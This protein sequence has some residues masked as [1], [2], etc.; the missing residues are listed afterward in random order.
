MWLYL[1]QGQ[2]GLGLLQLSAHFRNLQRFILNGIQ[3]FS[4]HIFNGNCQTHQPYLEC[5]AVVKGEKPSKRHIP[6]KASG[7]DAK[8]SEVIR[9]KIRTWCMFILKDRFYHSH[10]KDGG[11]KDINQGPPPGNVEGQSNPYSD[12]IGSQNQ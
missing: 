9:E 2:I 5:K 7:I 10:K 3:P 1:V 12:C 4:V 8:A 11:K 6:Q